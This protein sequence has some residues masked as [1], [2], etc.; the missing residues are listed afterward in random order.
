[1]TFFA[2]P[3]ALAAFEAQANVRLP[4]QGRHPEVLQLRQFEHR[5]HLQNVVDVVAEP[6][7]FSGGGCGLVEH[8]HVRFPFFSSRIFIPDPFVGQQVAQDRH[9]KQ[10]Y[11]VGQQVM[12]PQP[13]DQQG[14]DRTAQQQH[15]V[16]HRQEAHQPLPE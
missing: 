2:A 9:H 1:M 14:D 6:K 13:S 10:R 4:S 3:F 16:I 5:G 11:Q 15:Q 8:V 7:R 12:H